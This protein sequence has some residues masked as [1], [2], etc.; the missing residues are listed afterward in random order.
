MIDT[1]SLPAIAAIASAFLLAAWVLGR[2]TTRDGDRIAYE[3]E[4]EGEKRKAM[5][6]ATTKTVSPDSAPQIDD[7]PKGPPQ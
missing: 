4:R 2:R 6:D 1:E 3:I 5:R 7:S